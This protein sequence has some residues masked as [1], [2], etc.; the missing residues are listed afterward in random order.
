[1]YNRNEE[2][3]RKIDMQIN[4]AN[5]SRLCYSIHEAYGCFY[6]Y[7]SRSRTTRANGVMYLAIKVSILDG[8]T[9]PRKNSRQICAATEK[10]TL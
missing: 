4:Q 6:R 9:L 8:V 5:L 3:N 2:S 1:M 10:L 7:I